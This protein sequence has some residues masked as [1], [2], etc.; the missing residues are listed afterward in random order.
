MLSQYKSSDCKSLQQ[1]E[2]LIKKTKYKI[3]LKIKKE[4]TYLSKSHST[5]YKIAI[6]TAGKLTE[7]KTN[8]TEIIVTFGT[9]GRHKQIKVVIKTIT[10]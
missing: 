9:D 7:L 5:V 6:F 4:L 8:K 1:C 2:P 3:K 10:A